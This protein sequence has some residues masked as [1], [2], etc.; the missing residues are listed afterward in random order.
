[1]RRALA[2]RGAGAGRSTGRA[3]HGYPGP[4]RSLLNR[5]AMRQ[6]YWSLGAFCATCC[7]LLATHHLLEDEAMF[8]KLRTADRDLSPILQRL[9]EEH[10]LIVGL[11]TCLDQKL[12]RMIEF[13]VHK[14]A[15]L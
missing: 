8:R 2:A 7:R 9:E 14:A 4:A 13:N 6:N 5:M 11:I 10:E 3:G 15:D 1:M 12:V